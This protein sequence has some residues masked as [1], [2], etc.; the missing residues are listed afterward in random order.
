M[1]FLLF[2][3]IVILYGCSSQ[4][5]VSQSVEPD[6]GARIEKVEEPVASFDPDTVYDLM[7]AELGGQRK[8]YDLALGNYLK[9]AHKTQDAGVAKRAYQ[10]AMFIGAKQAALDASILWADLA[11]DDTEALQAS[12]IELIR[13]G[14]LSEAV[15][16]M[17]RILELEGEASFDFLAANAASLDEDSRQQLMAA[18]DNIL[19]KYPGSRDLLLGKAILL[20][21]M[22]E[23]EKALGLCNALLKKNPDYV[24]AMIVKGRALNRL[25]RADEAEK[26]LADAVKNYPG[27]P[28]LRLLYARVLVHANKLD[29]ARKEFEVLLKLSPH[30]GEIILSLALITMENNMDKEAEQYFNQLLALG[31]RKNTVHYYLGKLKAR[32]G[33]IDSA[34]KHFSEVGPGKNFMMTQVALAQML[35][36]ASRREE[37]YSAIDE[38]RK[39]FPAHAEPLY[40]LEGELLIEEGRPAKAKAL[41]DDALEYYPKSVNLLYSRAMTQEKLGRVDELE[42]D[43]RLVIELQPENAA[44]LNALGYTLADRTDRY[45]EAEALIL[46]AYELDAEDPAIMDSMGWIQYK[47]GN[48]L[49]AVKFLRMAYEKYP[50]QEVAAHLGEVL[51]VMG[52]REEAEKLWEQSL[53]DNP[54]S[55]LLRDTIHRLRNSPVSPSEKPEIT[56]VK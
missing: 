48:Y 46:K 45:K 26:M 23:S 31:Q 15:D 9:Q 2:F 32:Q 7:V 12:A 33:D 53:K 17:H 21:Q 24:K 13:S 8:R 18:F 14:Q 36:E 6:Q 28:R 47:L 30:D 5:T 25:G 52:N 16:G 44:A 40:L 37:A 49:E 27:R 54:D 4:Q 35:I 51:W 50:D 22:G 34:K 56:A 20:Q 3:L 38:S 42:K 11:P 1:K 29:K 55:K 19:R 41:F 39:R 10:I 43:L